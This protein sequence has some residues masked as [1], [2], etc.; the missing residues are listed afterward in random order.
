MKKLYFIRH[1]LSEMNVA[2]I[3][4]GRTN[5][6]LTNE[7]RQQA[8]IAGQAAKHIKIDL[9]V[10]SPLSRAHDTAKI[11]AK[12]IGYPIKQLQTNSLLIERDY[13]QLEGKPW[14]PDLNLDG[15]A[16][17]ET[18]EMLI[19][20]AQLALDWL[21]T[22]PAQ[23]IL[24]VSHGAFGRAM[25]SILKPEFDFEHPVRLSNAEIHEWL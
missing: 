12:E 20:R 7:G 1:G 2:G 13:G 16:D 8:K 22:L 25:R 10:C 5:T 19:T 11:I 9:I 17:L 14:T 24:V 4:S 18:A 15:V 3:V 21:H 6:S 23:H